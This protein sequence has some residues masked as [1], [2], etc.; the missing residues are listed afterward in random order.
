M[1]HDDQGHPFPGGL[2]EVE[3]PCGN[4]GI[5]KNKMK[6]VPKDKRT[7]GVKDQWQT[8]GTFR[9][10]VEEALQA[11]NSA[12][13]NEEDIDGIAVVLHKLGYLKIE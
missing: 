5:R 13:L 3:C 1:S 11:T 6:T 8:A 9:R 4:T 2:K 7:Y 12:Y 10:E